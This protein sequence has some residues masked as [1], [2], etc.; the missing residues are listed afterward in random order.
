MPKV[1]RWRNGRKESK[2]KM[3]IKMFKDHRRSLKSL[4]SSDPSQGSLLETSVSPPG[5]RCP[6]ARP[7]TCEFEME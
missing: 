5:A 1:V 4:K 3:K 2:G 6:F 7:H